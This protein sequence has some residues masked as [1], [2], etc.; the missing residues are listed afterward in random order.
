MKERIDK[1]ETSLESKLFSKLSTVISTKISEEMNVAK[2]ELETRQKI[3]E[4]IVND[5]SAEK[6]LIHEDIAALRLENSQ[7][8]DSLINHQ[9]YLENIEASRRVKNLIITGLPENNIETERCTVYIR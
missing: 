9:K 5:L 6:V 1:L 7:L 2:E 4:V 3:T 8:T